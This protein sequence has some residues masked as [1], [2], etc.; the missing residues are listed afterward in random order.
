[1][2]LINENNVDIAVMQTYR[3]I[4]VIYRR[5]LGIIVKIERHRRNK[6]SISSLNQRLTLLV[7]SSDMM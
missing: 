7:L 2:I 3:N 4:W 1:M 5:K 6:S